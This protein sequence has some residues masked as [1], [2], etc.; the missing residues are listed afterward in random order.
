MQHLKITVYFTPTCP[1]CTT[2]KRFFREK[3]IKFKEIDVSKDPKEA[4]KLVRKSGQ[5]G[6]PVIEIGN[7]IIVGFNKAK[8][9][10][11]LSN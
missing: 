11:I 1:H 3:G 6:V 2:A 10:S 9:E 4:E 8:I 7:K 5:M